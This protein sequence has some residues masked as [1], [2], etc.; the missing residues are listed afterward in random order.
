MAVKKHIIYCTVCSF[1]ELKVISSFGR[2][3]R[4]LAA[5]GSNFIQFQEVKKKRRRRGVEGEGVSRH[6]NVTA[7]MVEWRHC[8]GNFNCLTLGK[9]RG[10]KES[11]RERREGKD[12]KKGKY[13][14]GKISRETR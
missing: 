2:E 6:L 10:G 9:R 1:D 12:S 14:D 8:Q 5:V 13:I 4:G 3:D 7:F 11:T